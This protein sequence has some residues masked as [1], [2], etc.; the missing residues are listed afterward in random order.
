MLKKVL[1]VVLALVLTLGVCAIAVSAATAGDLQ[2]A[3]SKLPSDY[4]AKYYNDDTV[5]AIAAAKEAA[6]AAL[7]SGVGI[8]EAT[9]LCKST[10]AR[11]AESED[12]YIEADDD[13]VRKYVNRDESK[14]HAE[15]GLT[16]DAPAV[17]KAGDLVNVTLNLKADFYILTTVLGFAFDK[18]KLEYVEDSYP[19]YVKSELNTTI[20]PINTAWGSRPNGTMRD[21]GFFPEGKWSAEMQ[22]Q[23]GII[24]KMFIIDYATHSS[25]FYI[26]ET[27]DMFTI[28]FRVKEDVVDGEALVF[29][30]DG[31]E[32]TFE[33]SVCGD[34]LQPLIC[35]TRAASSD[36]TDIIARTDGREQQ[37]NIAID[38]QATASQTVTYT[39]KS[40]TL[41]FNQSNP[42]DY[43]A[44]EEAIA[45][46]DGFNAE[47]YTAES[48]AAFEQAVA[49]GVACPKDYS[50]ADQETV[51][52]YT[53]AIVNA[54]ERLIP[55]QAEG[56]KIL[57]VEP[58]NTVVIGQYANI[59]VKVEGNPIK[60]Q[61]VNAAG[62]T[63]TLTRTHTSVFEIVDNGDG[64]ETWNLKLKVYNMNELYQVF[65]KFASGWSQ[66]GY[67]FRLVDT[68]DFD[69]NVYSCSVA[70]AVDS[71]MYSG[72]HDVTV[73]TGLDVT[74]VQFV[75]NNGKTS[76]YTAENAS[77]TEVEGK[78]VWTINYNFSKLGDGQ[79]FNVF[80][81]SLASS[82]GDSGVA[83]VVDVLQK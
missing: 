10:L 1:S 40:L 53:T 32:R 31:F 74:K 69:G 46:I 65:A 68:H 2:T 78:L 82:F 28:T 24:C 35:F 42:A 33:N 54:R 13:Y 79:L 7:E 44:L 22:K 4:N 59:A 20:L 12:I 83:M 57:S 27:T 50:E 58:T 77:V 75:Y 21:D 9:A 71:R 51:D 60:L 8:D 62:N 56:C 72:Y 34:F 37:A 49:A 63:I 48:W 64:T 11:C 55:V 15:I 38:P 25:S 6:A 18:T 16:T 30:P 61:F 47:E 3:L 19:E 76:T 29:I 41:N 43:T 39:T 5:A 23:Y 67:K 81:R 14:A 80:S 73:V 52:A 26:P 70:D 66:P 36:V 17:L 45:S